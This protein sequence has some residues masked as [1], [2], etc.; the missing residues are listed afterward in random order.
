MQEINIVLGRRPEINVSLGELTIKP[1]I[2]DADPY[3]G[4]Y[5]VLPLPEPQVLPTEKKY[6]ARDIIVKSIPF[7]EVSNASGGT[8]VVIDRIKP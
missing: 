7:Y 1:V 3:T 2:G 4:E 6:C 8:T 5:D